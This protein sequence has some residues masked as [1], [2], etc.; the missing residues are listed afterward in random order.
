M[1]QMK[2]K[3]CVGYILLVEEDGFLVSLEFSDATLI[4]NDSSP[5]LRSV[6]KELNEYFQGKRKKFDIPFKI[7]GTKFQKVIWETMCNIPY[8][9]TISYGEL[10]ELAGYKKAYRAVGSACG[11]N[12]IA[13]IVPCHRVL[14]SNKKIGGFG[15]GLENKRIL[16]KIEGIQI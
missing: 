8:G 11:N 5:L 15:G 12:P 10:S 13:I 9:E 1:K 6:E 16:L 7:K 2:M 4:K 14:A 3:T